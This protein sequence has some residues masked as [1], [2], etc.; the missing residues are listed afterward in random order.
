M[1]HIEN[2]KEWL[3][4]YEEAVEKIELLGDY[5][6]TYEI[7]S[8]MRVNLEPNIREMQTIESMREKLERLK[9][10][11]DRYI[12]SYS[13]SISGPL[14]SGI[15][16]KFES[17]SPDFLNKDM[18]DARNGDNIILDERGVHIFREI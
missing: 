2:E 17:S 8:T 18:R 10:I 7:Y 3:K 15:S 1:Y 9:H 6:R 5:K 16:A 11:I 4:V 12:E 14:F 13:P